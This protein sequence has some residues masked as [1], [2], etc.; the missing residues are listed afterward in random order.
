MFLKQEKAIFC[1]F[2]NQ[3]WGKREKNRRFLPIFAP[4]MDFL[5]KLK[6]S[7]KK[8]K[9][10][11]GKT[12]ENIQKLKQNEHQVL[13][14]SQKKCKIKTPVSRYVVCRLGPGTVVNPIALPEYRSCF[15]AYPPLPSLKKLFYRSFLFY[16]RLP[17]IQYY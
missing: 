4:K 2:L 3:S 11:L 5:R 17:P 14:C 12:Q 8:L 7:G 1:V 15:S 16:G 13:C 6:Q 10:L 9:Q